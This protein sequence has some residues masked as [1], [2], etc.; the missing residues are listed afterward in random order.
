MI[1]PPSG[2]LSRGAVLKTGFDV[3]S[4]DALN[5]PERAVWRDGPSSQRCWR[6]IRSFYYQHI[7]LYYSLILSFT[8]PSAGVWVQ[9]QAVVKHFWTYVEKMG[10]FVCVCS[11]ELILIWLAKI[12][13]LEHI[14]INQKFMMNLVLWFSYTQTIWS[15]IIC[16]QTIKENKHWV[17]RIY[18]ITKRGRCLITLTG[19]NNMFTLPSCP[20]LK[21]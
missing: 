8:Y 5:G 4:Q 14:Q 17:C 19:L 11:T 10:R 6:R 21:I 9:G 12:F 3:S 16:I 13:F 1:A 18:E 15:Y 20:A 2:E 7:L